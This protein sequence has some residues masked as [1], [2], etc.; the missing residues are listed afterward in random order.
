MWRTIPIGSVDVVNW[1]P[2]RGLGL[3]YDKHHLYFFSDVKWKEIILKLLNAGQ[4]DPLVFVVRNSRC[5]LNLAL[6]SWMYS[7]GSSSHFQLDYQLQGLHFYE[8]DELSLI[9]LNCVAS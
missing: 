5:V 3:C 2:R 8:Q 4:G 7:L 1:S 6:G 9:Y